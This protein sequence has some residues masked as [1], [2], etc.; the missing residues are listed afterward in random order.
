VTVR[1]DASRLAVVGLAALAVVVALAGF[2]LAVK[3]QRSHARTLDGEIASAQLRLVSLHAAPAHAPDL[4]E[5]DLFQLARAMPDDADVAGILLDLSRVAGASKTTLV[6]V[7][8][9]T[10]VAL[11]DG[12]TAVP[13]SITVDGT[14]ARISRFLH[15][16][17]QQVRVHGSR[18]VVHGRAFDVDQIQLQSG[19]GAALEAV[20]TLSAFAY[21]TATTPATTGAATTTSEPPAGS[22]A[23]GAPAG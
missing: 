17:R 12:S 19:K 13:L 23:A 1:L 4:H 14:W 5:A 6:A 3:P 20:L 11:P 9:S 22:E 7:K 15:V 21:G 2:L 8:P 16:L 10:T 18:L